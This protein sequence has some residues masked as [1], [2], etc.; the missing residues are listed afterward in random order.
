MSRRAGGGMLKH[1]AD[2]NARGC[3]SANGKLLETICRNSPQLESRGRSKQRGC[4]RTRS[5]S[6]APLASASVH[7]QGCG[8]EWRGDMAGA[9]DYESDS[10]AL[11]HE[12]KSSHTG[13]ERKCALLCGRRRRHP[14]SSALVTQNGS[15]WQ[16]RHRIKRC[17]LYDILIYY[18]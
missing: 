1:A 9:D 16:T 2:A 4:A 11:L 6:E 5:V 10:D 8:Q 13:L 14:V 17:I 18:T 3:R 12:G 7:L 15:Q